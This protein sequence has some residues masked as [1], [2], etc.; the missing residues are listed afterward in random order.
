MWLILANYFMPILA[1]AVETSKQKTR[2]P[3]QY[4]ML[5]GVLVVSVAGAAYY[6]RKMVR[7]YRRKPD[8]LDVET[9]NQQIDESTIREGTDGGVVASDSGVTHTPKPKGSVGRLVDK[10]EAG[11]NKDA[12]VVVNMLQ[13]QQTFDPRRAAAPKRF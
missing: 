13:R 5:V 4:G 10:L 9:T 12:P 3:T 11:V 8:I 2:S 6:V 7:A 1:T